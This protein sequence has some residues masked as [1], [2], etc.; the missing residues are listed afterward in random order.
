MKDAS[1][2]PRDEEQVQYRLLHVPTNV[3]GSGNTRYAAAMY[4]HQCGALSSKALEIYRSLA[5]DD[6][7]DPQDAL[8]SA[9]CSEDM[10]FASVLN[11][12]HCKPDKN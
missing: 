11:T 10:A 7:S 8:K 4:F 5:K 6:H 2:T 1:P 3:V 9:G 12:L